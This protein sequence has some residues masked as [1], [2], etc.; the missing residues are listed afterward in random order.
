[1][2]FQFLFSLILPSY[3]FRFGQ[4]RLGAMRS[5]GFFWKVKNNFSVFFRLKSSKCSHVKTHVFERSFIFCSFC[6]Y[7]RSFKIEPSRGSPDSVS[8]HVITREDFIEVEHVRTCLLYFSSR[9]ILTVLIRK[10]SSILPQLTSFRLQ[11]PSSVPAFRGHV[12]HGVV[13][14][15]LEMFFVFASSEI[16]KLFSD[17]THVF[18]RYFIFCIFLF[19]LM[20]FW[21]GAF[22]W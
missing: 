11:G 18:E 13:W 17:K 4:L 9:K 6:L 1:M 2:I 21:N 22:T 8:D 20:D 10:L 15:K 16:F 12:F 14:L 7:W 5:T 3:H 19:V